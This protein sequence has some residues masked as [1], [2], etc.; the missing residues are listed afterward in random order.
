VEQSAAALSRNRHVLCEV[1]AAA[2]L[3]D[4]RTLLKAVRA[5][6]GKYMMAE[7]CNFWA[8]IE[9]WREIV[10][11]GRLGKI[12]YAET[13]YVHDMRDLLRGPDGQPTWRAMLP[14]IHYCT[15][16]LGPILSLT[17]DRCAKVTAFS[18]GA[19][20]LPGGP[21]DM[22]VA[23]FQTA[24]GALIKLLRGAIVERKPPLHYYSVYGARGVLETSRSPE[25][26]LGTTLSMFRDVPHLPR[27][28]KMPL[29]LH[30]P[31]VPPALAAGGHGTAEFVMARAFVRSIL[32]DTKP[33]VDI[34][35]ALNMTV[36]GL[37]AHLSAERGGE[38]LPIPDLAAEADAEEEAKAEKEEAKKK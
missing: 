17:E 37:I 36:P 4:C 7:N 22:E 26:P 34:A 11:Q 20:I 38:P 5:S 14:P 15:H 10:R 31:N 16:S 18:T 32:D 12:L 1:P 13:E 23:L 24:Q 30:H 19:N 2:N 35:H 33:P 25:D 8:F 21:I 27:M 9:S 3:Q 28:M 6:K 29:G